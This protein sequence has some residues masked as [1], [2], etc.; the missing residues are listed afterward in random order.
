MICD[1]NL[2]H[3]KRLV[4]LRVQNINYKQSDLGG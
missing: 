3:N 1:I 2:K 4:N